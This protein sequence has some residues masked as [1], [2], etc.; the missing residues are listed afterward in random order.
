MDRFINSI[1]SLSCE[2]HRVVFAQLQGASSW[3]A[4]LSHHTSIPEL[5]PGVKHCTHVRVP[6][7]H[8]TPVPQA[9]A[10]CMQ[11]EL[12][13]HCRKALIPPSSSQRVQEEESHCLSLQKINYNLSV[14]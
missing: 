10:Q 4:H 3:K 9:Q 8:I 6:C 14:Q 11:P 2:V 5:T 7:P 1:L 12:T 13:S